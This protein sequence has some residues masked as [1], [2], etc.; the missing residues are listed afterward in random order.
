MHSVKCQLSDAAIHSRIPILPCFI[1]C[2]KFCCFVYYVCPVKL[3][4]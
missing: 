3:T 2:C 4:L 1:Y